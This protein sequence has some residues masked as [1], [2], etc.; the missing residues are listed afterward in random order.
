A[1]ISHPFVT[2][3]IIAPSQVAHGKDLDY[4]LRIENPSAYVAHEVQVI[5][6][7]PKG[8]HLVKSDPKPT[9]M[10]EDAIWNIGTVAAGGRQEISLTV[11]PPTDLTEWTHTAR[12]RFEH[13]RQVKTKI[14]RPELGLKLIAQKEYQQFDIVTLR[15]EV[16]NPGLMEVKDV[17][18]NM[19]VP[20][21]T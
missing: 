9:A 16:N 18:V 17:T 20:D 5:H 14:A 7:L 3:T 11:T 19:Q 6:P 8:S 21:G 4:K 1:G 10:N 2:V 13:T 15:L 12:V